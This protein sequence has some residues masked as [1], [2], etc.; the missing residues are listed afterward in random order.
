MIFSIIK[1]A[2]AEAEL[3]THQHRIGAV[4]FNKKVIISSGR[5]YAC[6]SVKHLH[7]RF[8]RWQGSVHAEVDAIIKARRDLRNCSILV[9]RINNKGEF[10]LA[11]SCD[12]CMEYLKFTQ[13]RNLYFS[14]NEGTIERLVLK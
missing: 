9:V 3:S 14:T 12:F 5:N 11:Y 13:F 4:I 2:V 8:T 7:P 1:K 6:R 10:R